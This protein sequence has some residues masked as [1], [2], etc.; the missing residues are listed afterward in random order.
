[1]KSLYFLVYSI[2]LL[3]FGSLQAEIKYRVVEVPSIDD[4]TTLPFFINEKGLVAGQCR[5][6]DFLSEENEQ[7]LMGFVWNAKTGE[8]KTI[9][10]KKSHV[11]I[12]GLNDNNEVIG[13]LVKNNDDFYFH[14]GQGFIWTADKGNMILKK[15]TYKY[16]WPVSINNH[17]QIVGQRCDEKLGCSISLWEGKSVESLDRVVTKGLEYSWLP[18]PIAINDNGQILF[19]YKFD[20]ADEDQIDHAFI[21]DHSK[22][23]F[24]LS[25]EDILDEE[26]VYLTFGGLNNQGDIVGQRERLRG[27]LDSTDVA[28]IWNPYADK[29]ETPMSK[30]LANPNVKINDINDLRQVV[31]RILREDTGEY[32]GIWDEAN[33]LQNLNDLIDPS[34]GWNL[35]NAQSINNQGQ[36]VGYGLKDG[37]T[38]GFL[39]LPITNN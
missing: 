34:L 2:M 9:Q 29:K 1:M 10:D 22:R 15:G 4:K 3:G 20:N 21:W 32:A 24:F 35:I 33:D 5:N 37:K 25:L 8:H 27:G 17:G 16:S 38:A 7:L 19:Q 23:H 13:A 28:S 31:G 12:T 30:Q 18:F 14:L 36:I 26:R 39:L 6:E 11:A